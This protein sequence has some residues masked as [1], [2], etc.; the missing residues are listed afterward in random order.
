VRFL[1]DE[2]LDNRLLVGLRQAGHD[3]SAAREACP[4]ASDRVVLELARRERRVAVTEDKRI[5][6][7]IARSLV[8]P[9]GIVL[10]RMGRSDVRT[11][12]NRL[13]AAVERE[14]ERLHGLYVVVAEKRTRVRPI[15]VIRRTSS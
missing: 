7:L 1:A 3:V 5:G 2:C 13:L 14:D 4:A 15:S 8:E 6:R 10:V 12:V 11:M 9:P